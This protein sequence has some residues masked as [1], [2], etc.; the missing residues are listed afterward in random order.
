MARDKTDKKSA[1]TGAANEWGIPDW[2]DA[3]AY[4]DTER[5]TIDRWRWEFY[6]RR[7]DLRQYFD[8][9]VRLTSEALLVLPPPHL[10]PHE[11]DFAL[12]DDLTIRRF[13]YGLLPN[14]RISE[15]PP[16][17][18]KPTCENDGLNKVIDD[19]RLPIGDFLKVA[20][21]DETQALFWRAMLESGEGRF[22]L[23]RGEK[24]ALESMRDS[25][26]SRL[27]QSCLI[28][29]NNNQVALT[30]QIDRPI[31]QQLV[32]AKQV[33]SDLQKKK[34]CK[35][36]QKRRNRTKWLGFLRTLDAREAGATWREIAIALLP[37]R[38]DE[39]GERVHARETKARDTWK[40]ANALRFN[41]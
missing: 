7:D 15:Q 5:W 29:L 2:R 19:N 27:A 41:F 35:P 30:F 12:V 1:A 26:L 6:R 10:K 13:G 28:T 36:I 3:S 21:A 4:G 24:G 32:E 37:M 11:L 31:E 18:I 39:A 8:V 25:L 40:S 20:L 14:P 22:A 33:L 16:Q 9:A 17:L 23:P 38:K 34:K